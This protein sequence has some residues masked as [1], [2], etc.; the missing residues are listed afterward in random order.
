MARDTTVCSDEPTHPGGE[1]GQEQ[2]SDLSLRRGLGLAEC[3]P[4]VF[5]AIAVKQILSRMRYPALLVRMQETAASAPSSF[6]SQ[7]QGW[8]EM[9]DLTQ[10]RDT[11]RIHCKQAMF[12]L[13][14]S[15]TLL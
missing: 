13:A 14:G 1:G 8:R 3:I 11:L 4:A 15:L 2:R 12:A 9:W 6:C 5:T 7:Q 10:V